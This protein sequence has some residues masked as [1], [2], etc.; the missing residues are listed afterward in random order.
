[1]HTTAAP[2]VDFYIKL[3]YN[4]SVYF[5]EREKLFKVAPVSIMSMMEI[6]LRLLLLM[7]VLEFSFIFVSLEVV[8]TFVVIFRKVLMRMGSYNAQK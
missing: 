5:N 7:V 6:L 8:F 3:T 2:S 1:L 4:E